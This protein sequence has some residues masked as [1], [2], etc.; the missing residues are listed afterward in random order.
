MRPPGGEPFQKLLFLPPL[1]ERGGLRGPCWHPCHTVT[2]LCSGCSLVCEEGEPA[3]CSHSRWLRDSVGLLLVPRFPPI[4]ACSSPL[5]PAASPWTQD[6]W[7]SAADP[8]LLTCRHGE[9]A[10]GLPFSLSLFLKNL[11]IYWL[12]WV[13]VAMHGLSLVAASGGYSS[14]WRVGFSLRWLLLL[15]STGSRHAGFSRCGS[16]A[17]ERRLHSCSARA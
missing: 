13:S 16:W 2:L 14:L 15:Q 4:G 8:G 1:G 5:L 12:R 10:E 9:G 3:L 7:V 17:L 11:F 6:T